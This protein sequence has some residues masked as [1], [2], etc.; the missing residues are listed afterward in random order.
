MCSNHV[1]HGDHYLDSWIEK[2]RTNRCCDTHVGV[3]T[4]VYTHVL[5]FVID[6]WSMGLS[7]YQSTAFSRQWKTLVQVSKCSKTTKTL[8]CDLNESDVGVEL[9]GWKT[10]IFPFNSFMNT[11]LVLLIFACT[12]SFGNIIFASLDFKTAKTVGKCFL[13]FSRWC[14]LLFNCTC[15]HCSQKYKN[16]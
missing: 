3:R 16:Y 13:F 12:V 11:V 15:S 5:L 14:A 8:D 10:L 6:Y 1:Q 4:Y 9:N 7:R 2:S